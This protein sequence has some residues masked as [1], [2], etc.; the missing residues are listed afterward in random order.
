MLKRFAALAPLVVALTACGGGSSSGDSGTAP[1]PALTITEDNA[2]EVAAAVTSNALQD[3]E[4]PIGV[5]FIQNGLSGGGITKPSGA[6]QLALLEKTLEQ[7]RIQGV[8]A[9]PSSSTITV[10]CEASGTQTIAVNIGTEGQLSSGD[11]ISLRYDNCVDLDDEVYDGSIAVKITAVTGLAF[12]DIFGLTFNFVFSNFYNEYEGSSSTINGT[13]SVSISAEAEVLTSSVT[14]SS[15]T[16]TGDGIS[17]S[18]Q[19]YQTETTF[20][21]STGAYTMSVDGTLSSDEIGG[22]VNFDT[23]DVISGNASSGSGYPSAGI[24][25][26]TGANGSSL[27]LTV[28]S[29]TSVLLEI[30]ND[31]DGTIDATLNTTWVE[32]GTFAD[33]ETFF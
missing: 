19:N 23:I 25:E 16:G 12:G 13:Y 27:T 32:L 7:L 29:E 15:L 9:G 4:E 6:A 20:N 26:I 14:I 30:D 3:A 17:F 24:L 8:P 21:E 11:S 5:E 22:T 28:E 1:T 18:I 31:G 2:V 10:D 33:D